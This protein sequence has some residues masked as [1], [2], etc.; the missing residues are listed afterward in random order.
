MLRF[1]KSFDFNVFC[2]LF[3][4]FGVVAVTGVD[5][6]N[7]KATKR[8]CQ[9]IAPIRETLHGE[10]WSYGNDIEEKVS[11]FFLI[12]TNVVRQV[13][14]KKANR[15]IYTTMALIWKKCWESK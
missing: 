8:L 10:F 13:N 7:E 4:R 14:N 1:S 5:A 15:Q 6:R 3:L 2:R 12:L 9:E 11:L